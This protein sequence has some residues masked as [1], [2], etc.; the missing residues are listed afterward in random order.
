[1]RDRVVQDSQRR[2]EI[3]LGDDER[4][5]QRQHIALA[6]FERQP[7]GEA[8][9]HHL[10]GFAPRGHAASRELDAQQQP[11]A[12]DVG[13][14]RMTALHLAHPLERTGA[15]LTRALER[16]LALE[17]LSRRAITA[18]MGNTAPPRPLPSTT[19]SGTIP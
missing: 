17:T 8:V 14:E 19:M 6:D 13:N 11:N 16:P 2:I 10:L 18:A 1:G 4:R 5:R 3:A 12:A 7:M 9:I 15:E